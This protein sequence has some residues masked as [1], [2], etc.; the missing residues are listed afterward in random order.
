MANLTKQQLLQLRENKYV[1]A[2]LK[3]IQWSEGANYQTLVFGG[4]NNTQMSRYGYSRH[5]GELGFK[6]TENIKGKPV[7]S[8]A[9]G[10]YQFIVGTWRDVKSRIGLTDFS[11]LSQDL[12]AIQRLEDRGA[13]QPLLQGNVQ[14]AIYR[15]N[16]EWASLPGSPYDQ[17]TRPLSQVL[18]VFQRNLGGSALPVSSNAGYQTASYSFGADDLKVN[19]QTVKSIAVFIAVVTITAAILGAS[20]AV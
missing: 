12:A 3:T 5:P 1:Q 11:P 15:S 17:H 9:S 4:S 13:L 14:A 18:Q 7:T 16:K 10:A 20:G 6:R 2:F 19:P 8:T